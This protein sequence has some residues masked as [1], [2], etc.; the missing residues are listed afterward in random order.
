MFD[1]VK[2]LRQRLEDIFDRNNY[3]YR[4]YVAGSTKQVVLTTDI[5]AVIRVLND[6]VTPSAIGFKA[7]TH[8]V[9]AEIILYVIREMPGATNE[10]Y[11]FCLDKLS[12]IVDTVITDFARNPVLGRYIV[13]YVD[14]LRISDKPY[15]YCYGVIGLSLKRI[16]AIT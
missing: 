13:T 7:V 15:K 8:T 1:A 3:E 9:D 11:E 2:Q 10:S 4:V 5:T 6:N 16:D 12:E 14:R